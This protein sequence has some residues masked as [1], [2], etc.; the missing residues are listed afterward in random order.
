MSYFNVLLQHSLGE[1]EKSHAKPQTRQ[2]I[3]LI[4][5]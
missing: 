2:P 1:T 5:T 3:L 4:D